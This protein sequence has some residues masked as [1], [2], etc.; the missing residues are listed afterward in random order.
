MWEGGV[1]GCSFVSGAGLSPDVRGTISHGIMHVTD[2]LSTFVAGIAGGS[3]APTGRP[4]KTCVDPVPPLD[5]HNQWPML[6]T[7]APSSRSEV[8]LGMTGA[9]S[10]ASGLTECNVP[11]ESAIRVGKWKLIHG[12]SAVYGAS[13]GP[14]SGLLCA[15]RSSSTEQWYA[16]GALPSGEPDKVMIPQNQTNP[17]CPNGWTPPPQRTGYQLPIPPPDSGCKG[18]PCTLAANATYF[19]GSTWLFDVETDPFEHHDVAAQNPDVVH[20]ILLRLQQFNASNVTQ[21]KGKFPGWPAARRIR[22]GRGRVP[23]KWATVCADRILARSVDTCGQPRVDAAIWRPTPST[24][25]NIPPHSFGTTCTF[26]GVAHSS[27][28]TWRMVTAMHNHRVSRPRIGSQQVWKRVDTLAWKPQPD[29]LRHQHNKPHPVRVSPVTCV[30]ATSR[31]PLG[32]ETP[33]LPHTQ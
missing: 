3:T 10:C 11:G 1:R 14:K 28:S 22:R 17:W 25:A 9:R 13:P 5:G 20:E 30:E 33:F 24:H 32:L 29:G 6:S 8:L 27:P 23:L 12:H 2:W 7:G 16:H 21:H 26:P 4:C 18:L 15:A 19:S 31:P